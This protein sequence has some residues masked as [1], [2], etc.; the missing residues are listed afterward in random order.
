MTALDATA[1]TATASSRSDKSGKP[2]G[3][4]EEIDETGPGEGAADGAEGGGSM[5]AVFILRGGMGRA[6]SPH[7][8]I[9][10][11]GP[12]WYGDR[13]LALNPRAPTAH[14]YTSPGHRPG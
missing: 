1:K 13:P 6:F 9:T 4:V 2:L 14:P 5:S 10:A 7:R 12:G 8:I 11:D 3:P